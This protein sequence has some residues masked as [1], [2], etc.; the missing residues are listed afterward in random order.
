ME[1]DARTRSIVPG[2]VDHAAAAAGADRR[3]ALGAPRRGDAQFRIEQR[4]ADASRPSSFRPTSPPATI[5]WPSCSI[6]A[7]AAIR[8]PFLNCTNCGP[9]LTII[10]GAPYDRERT[11]MAGFAMCPACRAEYDD[12]RQPPVPRPAD[13]AAR[14]AVRSCSL[15]WTRWGNPVAD[16]DPLAAFAVDVP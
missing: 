15:T 4:A 13:R 2:R 16:D 9:R 14:P 10:T 8:Y 11:T 6:P 12:P 1:G 7:I 3:P 5:A